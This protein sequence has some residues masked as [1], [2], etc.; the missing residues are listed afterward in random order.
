V[1]GWGVNFR[2]G[3]S[4][5]TKL[6]QNE[7]NG[8][9]EIGTVT[10]RGQ[11]ALGQSL[12]GV[13]APGNE[14]DAAYVDSFEL[15][16]GEGNDLVVGGPGNDTVLGDEGDDALLG[17][18]GDD[19][20]F[21]GEGDD[22]LAGNIGNDYL[23]GGPG[24][25]TLQGEDGDDTLF[26]GDGADFLYGDINFLDGPF[27]T[28]G[29]DYLDGGDGDDTLFGFG[30]AD[31][32]FG[33]DGAD[34]LHGDA[35]F[36][37][38]EF[39][40][41]DYLDG[42]GGN[43]ILLGYGGDDELFGGDGQDELQGGVGDDYLDGEAGDDT[44][45]GEVGGD[46]LYGGT[47]D[48]QLVGG[49]D[50]DYLDGEDGNDKIFGG[51][52]E[53]TL[54]G[55]ADDDQLNG[56]AEN[57]VLYG[58]AGADVVSG[59]DGD[60]LLSG[61][62]DADTL[63]GGS[64]DDTYLIAPSDQHDTI[65]D[66]EGSN[67][68]RFLATA[69]PA[70]LKI[71]QG[72]TSTDFTIEYGFAGD[73]LSVAGGFASAIT[74]FEFAYGSVYTLKQMLDLAEAEPVVLTGPGNGATLYGASKNDTLT[75]GASDALHGGRGDDLLNGSSEST[76]FEFSQGDGH[77]L[78][79]GTGYRTFRFDTSVSRNSL[80]A[81]KADPHAP[82]TLTPRDLVL[83]YGDPDTIAVEDNARAPFQ[84]YIFEEG[85]LTHVEML[86]QS[87]LALDW[88]GTSESE[89][90]S[91][92]RYDDHLVGAGGGD[93]LQGRD[94]DD[95]LE[96]ASGSDTLW[97][98]GGDDVLAGGA[99]D[100]T[101]QGGSGNDVLTGGQGN[102]TL[103]GG[104]GNDR[105]L[106]NAG[107]G[108]DIVD[109]NAG[110]NLIEFG[111]GVTV[112]GVGAELVNGTD[113][114]LYLAVR[115][116]AADAL[117]VKQNFGASAGDGTLTF[118][119]SDGTRLSTAE[120]SGLKFNAPL[121][122]QGT[123]QAIRLTGSG[124]DD[125]LIGSIR[126]DRLE[127]GEGNDRLAGDSGN[128]TLFGGAGDDLLVGNAGNDVLDGGSGADSY[129][130]H[131]GM[132]RDTIVEHLNESSTLVIDQGIAASDL[133]QHR[134]GNDLYLNIANS[135]D[136][137]QIQGYLVP[138]S[139]ASAQSWQV[140]F[141]DGTTTTLQTLIGTVAES[142]LPATVDELIADF[143]VRTK[144]FYESALIAAGYQRQANGSFLKD[145]TYSSDF[146]SSHTITTFKFGFPAQVSDAAFVSRDNPSLQ[147]I[148]NALST[149]V[150]H[151]SITR[152]NTFG[153]VL[154]PMGAG[155]NFWPSTGSLGYAVVSGE[156]TSIGNAG[157]V[158]VSLPP[159][160]ARPNPFSGVSELYPP[161]G[162]YLFPKNTTPT[163][164]TQPV[165]HSH[166]EQAIENR[167][168]IASITGGGTNSTIAAAPPIVM[169]GGAGIRP[170][171]A[172]ARGPRRGL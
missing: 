106:Q 42:E 113:G 134:L 18:R 170:T 107:D 80:T 98:D 114:N 61:G 89:W 121:N 123:D 164:F 13:V 151:P 44:L 7:A 10:L 74:T 117:L 162:F 148:S 56:G 101:L 104:F 152:L 71:A 127:G 138:G 76:F 48:D 28:H 128:D 108:V 39:Q 157:D 111:A 119:F 67:R 105:Y 91:G 70:D 137:V 115:Y 135:R 23:D 158:V 131:R 35:E 55:G 29:S 103:A 85:T 100:D 31:T 154:V 50:A 22:L 64:G 17:Q 126:D 14:A 77:D 144:T 49:E 32:L 110:E 161:G 68:I 155:A 47:G 168:N 11:S 149:S 2:D 122:L 109:D 83:K 26:G 81:Q 27:D 88:I 24:A 72:G 5:G 45:F 156:S 118:S 84:Q 133:T 6:Q 159:A 93:T 54:I 59:D 99:N 63:L 62:S 130:F 58:G 57:D 143:K 102:D 150:T 52:G 19:T 25:D 140:R 43:D 172:P 120:F 160:L 46:E 169:D 96:A 82:E 79:R 145:E 153:G 4:W 87:G 37:P 53:D 34:V 65:Q 146:S 66:T 124:S 36:L 163:Y 16:G 92:T 167:V 15:L 116:T 78:I 112:Q 8:S 38:D 125:T 12:E 9:L 90:V 41:D 21:G 51:A 165:T 139:P 142:V 97:G 30:G 20:M 166:T 95:V 147:L 86:E 60:D 94:G 73:T 141:A 69:S 132:G 75:S 136:G 3:F 33:G 40:S 171:F 129:R 1:G